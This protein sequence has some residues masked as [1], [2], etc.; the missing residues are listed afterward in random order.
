MSLVN[1]VGW[2]VGFEVETVDYHLCDNKNAFTTNSYYYPQLYKPVMPR[3]SISPPGAA[4]LRAMI[5]SFI[6]THMNR[7]RTG[8]SGSWVCIIPGPTNVACF[9]CVFLY[10]TKGCHADVQ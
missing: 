6:S 1:E 9:C 5:K 7:A 10:R 4:R 3:G 8:K 2:T